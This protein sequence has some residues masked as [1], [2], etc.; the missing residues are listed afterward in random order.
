MS[1]GGIRDHLGGGFHRYSVDEFWHVPHF[2]KMLYDQAQIAASLVEAWQI[3]KD[4][5]FVA[6]V[7]STLDY[8]LRDLTHPEGGFFCAEDADS[9][10]APGSS[11]HAEGAFYVWS[12]EEI[13]AALGIG[14]AREFCDHYDVRTEGNAPAGSDPHGEF[15]GKNI[16]HETQAGGSVSLAE[17]R[18]ILLSRRAAR[19]RPHLDDKILTAWNGLMISALAKA[20]AA[21]GEERYVQAA[22]QAAEFAESRLMRD[23]DLLRSWRNTPSD[24][25]GFAEDHAFFIQGLLDLY[26]AGFNLHWIELAA[27]LQRR[28]DELFW[29]GDSYFSSRAGDPLVPLRMKEDYD[30]AEPSANSVSALNLLRLGRMLHDEAFEKKAGRILASHAEQ[31]DRAPSAVPQMLVALDLALHSPS[32]AIVAGSQAA[33]SSFLA[34]LRQTFR[35]HTSTVLLDSADSQAFFGKNSPAVLAM[36]PGPDGPLLYLCEN[37]EC[38][39]PVPI[40]A[41]S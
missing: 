13:E 19:P 22:A 39:A 38:Q 1:C 37:F 23:G 36:N 2:E 11:A 12:R 26:E 6:T 21:L 30:G 31:M 40:G 25:C 34:G 41:G 10:L 14:A 18:A 20:G 3:T 28:Q 15:T 7:R 17:S 35:P 16:L 29:S 32:A 4:P 5:F 9:L 33:A 8:V 27:A 24:I